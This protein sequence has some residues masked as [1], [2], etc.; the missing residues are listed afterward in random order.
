MASLVPTTAGIP[1][2]LDTIAAWA[3]KPPSSVI[4]AADFCMLTTISGLVIFVT[5]ISP[6]FILSRSARSFIIFIFP[7]PIPGEAPNPE[8]ITSP[9]IS[10]SS[11]FFPIVVTALV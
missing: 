6:C 9:S 2:S 10:L 1:I 5:K 8:S 3:V 4:I 11:S 7:E